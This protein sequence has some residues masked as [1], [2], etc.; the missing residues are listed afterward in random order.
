MRRPWTRLLVSAAV[1]AA[2]FLVGWLP[3]PGADLDGGGLLGLFNRPAVTA[4]SLGLGPLLDGAVL[5]ELVALCIPALR[6]RRS[7]PPERGRGLT[8]AA[9][10]TALAIAAIQAWSIVLY[11]EGAQFQMGG[12][13]SPV[14]RFAQGATLVAA[15]FALWGL[16]RLADRFG[17]GNGIALL[18]GAQAA[19]EIG[20]GLYRGFAGGA[21]P[22]DLGAVA[23]ALSVVAA[24]TVF[25]L[26]G[27]RDRTSRLHLRLPASGALPNAMAP[28]LIALAFTAM[29]FGSGSGPEWL[30]PGEL[31]YL[32]LQAALAAGLAVAL[33]AAF[34][35]PAAAAR[36]L[37]RLPPSGSLDPAAE[38][39][40]LARPAWRGSVVFALIA[41]GASAL[42]VRA[43]VQA[44]PLSAMVLAACALDFAAEWRARTARGALAA[45]WH[46]TQP[47]QVEP[48]LAALAAA[49]VDGT[50]R[51]VAQRALWQIGGPLFPIEIL[52][53]P[54]KLPPAQAALAAL[55]DGAAPVPLLGP[56]GPAAPA[57]AVAPTR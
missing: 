3:L 37:A 35:R 7:G 43:R 9:G 13:R 12:A 4:G 19:A 26:R 40:A 32:A 45:A 38:A 22:I 47:W 17:L 53:A 23:L 16:A 5:V 29:L 2:Y 25:G 11:I 15:L 36:L 52:V 44:S 41:V 48:A 50:A 46:L 56:G 31:G 10:L 1:V 20:G 28:S 54:E 49:G 18:V 6:R 34:Y 33:A 21:T 51:T 39:R 27:P 42:I 57:G 8:L 30:A 14:P 24:A 55:F